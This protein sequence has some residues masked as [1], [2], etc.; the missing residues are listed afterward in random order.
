MKG[1]NFTCIRDNGKKL[2]KIDRFLVSHD[3]F[4]KWPDAVLRGLPSRFSDHRPLI[5]SFYRS[6]FGAKPFRMFNSWIGKPGFH[7]TVVKVLSQQDFAGPPDSRLSKKLLKVRQALKLWREESRKKEGDT[8]SKAEEEI[9]L[10]EETMEN[11]DLSEKEQWTYCENKKVVL[12]FEYR[13]CADMKQ[14]SRARWALDGDENT[15]FFHSF[16]N[17]RKASNQIPGL[18]INDRWVTK[19]SKIKKEVMC[20][21]RERFREDIKVRPSVFC[22]D[23]RTLSDT[24]KELL[25]KQFSVEE[26]KQA[27]Q[28]C[29]DDKAPGPDGFNMKFIKLLWEFLEK[30]FKDILDYFYDNEGFNIGCCSSFITLV[31]K[32]KDPVEL[33]NYRPINLIGVISKVVSKVLANRLK[34]VIGSV[35]SESQSAFIKDNYILDGPL[36]INEITNWGKKLT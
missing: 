33:N 13:K 3:F 8:L 18:V 10:L 28:D 20:F 9:E 29:G 11:R 21:F 27:V 5:L 16:V 7:E 32:K 2:S 36:M 35:I 23:L 17:M 19:P 4:S 14:R 31:P 6:N 30:D 1:K 15:K 25:I 12:D 26:I 34:V 22:D 24:E